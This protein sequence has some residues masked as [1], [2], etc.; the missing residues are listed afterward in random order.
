MKADVIEALKNEFSK[1]NINV[2][3]KNTYSTVYCIIMDLK[4]FVNNKEYYKQQSLTHAKEVRSTY[5]IEQHVL[6]LSNLYNRL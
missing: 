3:I 4:P 5:S 1:N 2:D 6:A